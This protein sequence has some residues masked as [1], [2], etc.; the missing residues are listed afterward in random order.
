MSNGRVQ[1]PSDCQRELEAHELLVARA[2]L[3]GRVRPARVDHHATANQRPVL[4]AD[5]RRAD[6]GD[7]PVEE[8]ANP[9]LHEPSGD[10]LGKPFAGDGRVAGFEDSL[11]AREADLLLRPLPRHQRRHQFR[12]VARRGRSDETTRCDCR[13]GAVRAR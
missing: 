4:E 11:V 10:H 1:G 13:R 2:R 5:Q 8:K 7:P 6:A 12:F 9:G 3:R